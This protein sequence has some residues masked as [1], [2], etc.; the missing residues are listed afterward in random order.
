[1]DVR[2]PDDA[3][4]PGSD[5]LLSIGSALGRSTGLTR[6]GIH[7]ELLP[8]GRRTSYPHAEADEEEFV[9]VLEGAPSVWIDGELHPLSV[10]DAVG[11]PA[12]T[13]FAHSFLND[14]DGPVRLLVVGEA[15][16]PHHRI[17]YP[18]DPERNEARAERHWRDAPPR[19]L[20]A[21]DGKPSRAPVALGVPTLSTPRL[22]LRP[23]R[24]EDAAAIFAMRTHPDAMRFLSG[25]PPSD[26][27]A[28]EERI[29]RVIARVDALDM[30]GWTIALRPGVEGAVDDRFVGLVG[31]V[32]IDRENAKAE[33]GYELDHAHWGKG[34]MREAAACVVAHAFDV[35]GLHRLEIRTDTEN[36]RSRRVALA[37]GFEQEGVLRHDER[38]PDGTWR[39]TV[40]FARLAPASST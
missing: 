23:H 15:S 32:R 30:L 18:L 34:I 31:V 19:P 16:K 20:G 13:G 38:A 9:Y 21:H 22:V 12:G 10:G 4:Y 1:M 8:P 36:D 11:Y 39:D 17:H 28:V 29:R 37:L 7:H 27:A 33:I 14:T 40:V 6:I 5:E 35:V 26:L 2:A 24:V 25:G 3:H